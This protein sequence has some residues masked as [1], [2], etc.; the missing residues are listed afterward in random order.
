[1]KP[2]VVWMTGE[3]AAAHAGYS[4]AYLARLAAADEIP[5]HR[6]AGSKRGPWRYRQDELDEWL[7]GQWRPARHLRPA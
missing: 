4:T 5:A 6:R 2:P 7:S 1:V 3:Q